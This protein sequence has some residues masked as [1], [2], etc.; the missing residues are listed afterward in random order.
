MPMSFTV[1]HTELEMGTFSSLSSAVHS[2]SIL[3]MRGSVLG[4]FFLVTGFWPIL[5]ALWRGTSAVSF[6]VSNRDGVMK[7]AHRAE[8][9]ISMMVNHMFAC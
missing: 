6:C 5:G 4:F 8:M 3:F 7:T 2:A 1:G 9:S